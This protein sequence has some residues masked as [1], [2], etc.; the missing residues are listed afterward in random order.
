MLKP[1]I[2]IVATLLALALT[3]AFAKTYKCKDAKGNTYYTDR[4]P[5][6][7]TGK[8]MDV[9]STQGTVLRSREAALTPEQRAAR[10]AKEKREEEEAAAAREQKRQD[11]ALLTTYSGEKDIEDGRERALKQAEQATREIHKR[12]AEA[13][14]RAKKFEAEKEFYRNKPIP[15]KLTD[16]IK[17]N[18]IDLKSQQESLAR[19]QKDI[20]EINAKYD[21]DKRRYLELT[22]A[23]PKEAAKR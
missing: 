18:E 15:K 9:L 23:K 21:E 5:A 2:L 4:P 3:P 19:K 17:N 1:Q 12:I 13:N 20:D 14:K 6:E 10:E 7:C 16:D 11:R 22:G 8:K